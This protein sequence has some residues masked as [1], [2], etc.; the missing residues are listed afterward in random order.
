MLLGP[1]WYIMLILDALE[2]S[3]GAPC[4]VRRLRRGMSDWAS[5]ARWRHNGGSFDLSAVN[6]DQLIFNVSGGQLVELR[7]GSRRIQSR[8]RA[9]SIA[10]TSPGQP[11]SVSVIGSADILQI[12]I[13]REPGRG[14]APSPPTPGMH[15][16]PRLRAFA[17]QALVALA[18]SR[19]GE[20]AELSAIVTAIARWIARPALTAPAHLRGGLS[21]AA[22]QRVQMLIYSRLEA[23]PWASPSLQELADAARLSMYHF[24][25]AFR[26][27]QGQTPHAYVLARRIDHAVGL[28]LRSYGQVDQIGEMSGFSSPAHFV[29]AFR[30]HV[31]VTP[32]ALRDA[33]HA[34]H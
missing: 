33:V 32:G 5:V 7:S 31:G 10:V 23:A 4:S 9:G 18:R 8:I 11:E 27:T 13:R 17:A 2:S 15:D 28:L 3:I 20:S 16:D 24:A 19:G 26:E 21:P 29:S 14:G 25:R 34:V 22:R 30:A 1:L 6:T 12:S